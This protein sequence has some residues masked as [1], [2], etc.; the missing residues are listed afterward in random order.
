MSTTGTIATTVELRV[1]A[2]RRGE[3]IIESA[4]K[5]SAAS[6]LIRAFV[7]EMALYGYLVDPAD[8]SRAKVKDLADTL[9]A[10]Q[11]VVGADRSFT[12]MYPDFPKGVQVTDDL[13]LFV[14]QIVHYLTG[15]VPDLPKSERSS[16]PKVDFRR[17]VRLRVVGANDIFLYD[18]MAR[19]TAIGADDRSALFSA[20]DSAVS[21]AGDVSELLTLVTGLIDEAG[22]SENV[23][24]LLSALRSADEYD[25]VVGGYV[26][27]IFETAARAARNPDDIL[28]V[29]LGLYARFEDKV[30]HSRASVAEEYR[31]AVFGLNHRNFYLVAFNPMPKAARRTLVDRLGRVTPGFRAD[32]LYSRRAIWQQVMRSVHPYSLSNAKVGANRRALDIIHENMKYVTLNSYY[33]SLLA[34]GS[35]NAIRLAVDTLAK[36]RPAMLYRNLVTLADRADGRKTVLSGL[37]QGLVTAGRTLPFTTIVAAYNSVLGADYAGARV[38]R[39][40]GSRNAMI[41]T[42]VRQ[43]KEVET[44]LDALRSVMTTRLADTVSLDSGSGVVGTLS[45]DPFPVMSRDSASGTDRV[46]T[47]GQRVTPPGEGD[48]IR[49]FVQWYNGDHHR[50][51]LDLG[52]AILDE[53][54]NFVA[55][56]SWNNYR[57]E[58]GYATYSGDLIDAPGRQGACEFIDVDVEE[59]RKVHPRAAY[60]GMS[61]YSYTGQTLPTVDHF[62]GV[63]YRSAQGFQGE[64]FDPRS[65]EASASSQQ[66]SVSAVPFVY[67]LDSGEA[68]WTDTSSGGGY[69]GMSIMDDPETIQAIRDEVSR[70]RLTIGEV[71]QMWANAHGVDTNPQAPAPR[72]EVLAL[73]ML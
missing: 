72:E 59:L 25:S 36:Y 11:R 30:P 57:T 70:P 48:V 22:N 45:D 69:G 64:I 13:T 44:I 4:A 65:V 42:K 52:A 26:H 73:L 38:S 24:W 40:A 46:L 43:I 32:M 39:S 15:M 49:L 19:K 51:D 63:M 8:I 62:F 56:V 58:R 2:L 6:T 37:T 71:A 31:N 27:Q 68:I 18:I 12:P 53:D 1:S 23:Q 28:R 66:N 61:V 10:A 21:S 60:V 55:G 34:D 33:E 54:F 3:M 35:A 20:V 9:V 5:R 7:G 29:V 17:S 41:Q 14:D 16:L 47:R 67:S 50:V